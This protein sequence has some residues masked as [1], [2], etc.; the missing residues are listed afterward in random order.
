MGLHVCFSHPRQLHRYKV[1]CSSKPAF[2]E[3]AVKL[4]SDYLH[5][6]YS[7]RH[8]NRYFSSFMRRHTQQ[9]HPTC[10][11]QAYKDAFS[12]IGIRGETYSCPLTAINF[13]FNGG[14]ARTVHGASTGQRCLLSCISSSECISSQFS[15]GL[16]CSRYLHA[17]ITWPNGRP[18][19]GTSCL[20][21]APPN[22]SRF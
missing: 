15:P 13:K 16:C 14:A 4:Y 18:A 6:G 17:I 20:P 2:I 21:L 10:V 5:K 19:D 7:Q 22:N 12:P 11:Q 3:S 8:T 9:C 1:A